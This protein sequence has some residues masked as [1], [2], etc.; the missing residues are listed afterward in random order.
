MWALDRGT[1]F[2][3]EVGYH[4][5]LGPGEIWYR[6]GFV[7][8]R[9]RGRNVFK[10][11]LDA[12]ASGPF[13]EFK[14]M[15]SDFEPKNRP[16]FKAH[17]KYGFEMVGTVRGVH[18]GRLVLFRRSAIPGFDRLDGFKPGRNI[19]FTGPAFA[20]YFNEHLA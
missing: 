14:T 5:P 2:V 6:D 1:R 15:W 13:R 3:D 16:S 4:F 7:S 19:I 20:R 18:V 8:A 12:L 9:M 17:E 11:L 10:A